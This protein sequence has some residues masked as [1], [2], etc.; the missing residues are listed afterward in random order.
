MIIIYQLHSK[1]LKM[2]D[3]R[4]MHPYSVEIY[5]L[6]LVCISNVFTNQVHK[7]HEAAR[8]VQLRIINT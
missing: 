5:P 2:S 4:H 6:R 3:V 8:S 7:S 1:R